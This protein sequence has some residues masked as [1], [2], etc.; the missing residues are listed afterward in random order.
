MRLADGSAAARRLQDVQRCS[1]QAVHVVMVY[2]CWCSTAGHQQYGVRCAPRAYQTAMPVSLQ[3]R[4]S[5][6]KVTQHG[7]FLS[8]SNSLWLIGACIRGMQ[9]V[10]EYQ[11]R[12]QPAAG[13]RQQ[14]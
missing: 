12:Q 4:E 7:C 1:V 14:Q 13:L 11:Q 3:N 6:Y 10:P 5:N 2:S 9:W 8:S